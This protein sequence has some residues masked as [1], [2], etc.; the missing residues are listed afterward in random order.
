MFLTSALNTDNT[1]KYPTRAIKTHYRE[2]GTRNHTN[3]LRFAMDQ[4]HTNL[5]TFKFYLKY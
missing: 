5:I 3:K 4:R 1:C 2:K